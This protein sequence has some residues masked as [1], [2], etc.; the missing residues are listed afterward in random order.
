[1]QSHKDEFIAS[2]GHELRTPMNAILGLNGVL[3]TEL[4]NQAEDLQIARHIRDSTQQLLRL[5]NDIL[6]FSQLEAGQLN[7]LEAPLHLAQTLRNVLVVFEAR[8]AEKSLQLYSTL[9]PELPEWVSLDVQR[10]QQ[11]LENLLDNALKFTPS[12]SVRLGLR[13]HQGRLRFEVEDTGR[14]IAQ[15]RQQQVFNRFEHADQQTKRAYG[16]TGLGLA[17]CERL[18]SLQGGQIGVCSDL[19]RGALFWFELPLQPAAPPRP[20]AQQPAVP[21]QVQPLSILLVDDNAVNLMVAQLVLEKCWPDARVTHATSGEA[22]LAQLDTQRFD[23]VLMDVVMPG[24]DGLET[25]RRLRRHAQAEVARTPVLGL[26]AS[27]LVHE[28]ERCLHAGMNNVL[29]KPIDARSVQDMVERLTGRVSRVLGVA[30]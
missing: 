11:I 5:V 15:E 8:A 3:Q 13:E 19:G 16:G 22:A 4:A 2:V 20:A 1:V 30:A 18:V 21:T 23:L 27:T 7:L 9:A 12:G 14:G 26:T 28:R 17:I 24:L 6:D 25:T 29:A 10:L